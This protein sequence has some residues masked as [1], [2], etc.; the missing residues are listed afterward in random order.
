MDSARLKLLIAL[1]AGLLCALVVWI[2]FGVGIGVPGEQA[3][4]VRGGPTLGLTGDLGRAEESDPTEPLQRDAIEVEEKARPRVGIA[5][6]CRRGLDQPLHRLGETLVLKHPHEDVPS[7]GA[8]L[9]TRGKHPT[10]DREGR[11]LVQVT[12][13]QI[14]ARTNSATTSARA[15][16]G[17]PAQCGIH[18]RCGIPAV[19]KASIRQTRTRGSTGHGFVS[20]SSK[21][22]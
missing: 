10:L 9:R 13:P 20:Q 1:G 8:P 3:P 4:E 16:S 18:T 7:C 2:T 6:R 14:L 22:T 11:L 5:E 12:F 19:D 21:R 15:R 17:R